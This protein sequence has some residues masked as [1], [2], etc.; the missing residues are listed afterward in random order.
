MADFVAEVRCNLFW[1]VIPFV[2]DLI[3]DGSGP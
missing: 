1:P 2:C 3:R